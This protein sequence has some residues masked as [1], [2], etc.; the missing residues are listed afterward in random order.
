LYEVKRALKPNGLFLLSFHTGSERITATNNEGCVEYI[1]HDFERIHNYIK[2]AEFSILEGVIRL[3]TQMSSTQADGLT[4]YWQIS[5]M[6][7][8][9]DCGP[10]IFTEKLP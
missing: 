4:F 5:K 10:T 9:V 2:E 6:D 3:P 1:F 7:F 8:K